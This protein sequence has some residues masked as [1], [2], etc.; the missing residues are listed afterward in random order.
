MT[1]LYRGLRQ[2]VNDSEP[3]AAALARELGL[4]VTAVE[5]E[6]EAL[7]ARRKPAV[8]RV[9]NLRFDV[10]APS[11]QLDRLLRDRRIVADA[12]ESMRPPEPY[13]ALRERPVIVGC[14]P[15]GLF[16]GLELARLGH[17]PILLERGQPVAQR[18]VAVERLWA[19]GELDPESNMQFGEG[20]AGA[21][22]DGKLSTG[23]SSPLDRQILAELVAAGAPAEV[24]VSAKPHIGTDRL[25]QVVAAL[26]QQIEALGG[27]VRFGARVD[28]L[29]TDGGAMVGVRVGGEI[30]RTDAVVLAIG[31]SARDT[32]AML[33]RV[34]V[35]MAVKPFALGLRIEHPAAFINEAQYGP[36]A[37][38]LL[39]A[40]DYKLTYTFRGTGVYSFCMCPGGEV[41]C[42]ASELAGQVTNGMS[43]HARDGAYSN[44][45]LVVAVDPE[46]LGRQAPLDA[47]AYQRELEQAAFQLGGGAFG[48]PAQR[49]RDFMQ[50]RLTPA[51]PDTTYRPAA[52]SARLD[53]LL[54]AFAARALATG[55]ESFDRSMPGFSEHGLLLGVE[56]RTS[57]PVRLVRDE[58]A[59]SVSLRGLYVLGE[60]SGYAG[61]IMTCARDGLRWAR[62]VLPRG[63]D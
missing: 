32:L 17:R 16:A 1:Y 25:R 10:A 53:E 61:G 36:R 59:Q 62:Q 51:L 33:Q 2:A 18:A 9:Y 29:E 57:S 35:A 11:M 6:R 41:V 37:A 46:R 43:Y 21:F 54:P 12:P 13:L 8:Y 38:A 34:G 48:A 56:T 3:L 50:R 4:E 7:D 24:L 14:G 42:A 40:A 63:A 5:V 60:G 58:Q 15:A 45:A 52:V 31:H 26:R 30:I 19:R 22:S 44:S 20:G 27:E 23:R 55:L 39:P 28:G 47:V 49:A